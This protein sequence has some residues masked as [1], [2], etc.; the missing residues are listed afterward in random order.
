LG[1]SLFGGD[2]SISG[3]LFAEGDRFEM[4][5]TLLVTEGISGSLT[6]LTDGTS[7]LI[8]GT[9]TTIV[10]QS[11][12]SVVISSTPSTP[13]DSVQYN[14][15]GV[16]GGSSNFT[17]NGTQVFVGGTLRVG[18]SAVANG[19]NSIASGE[20]S[21]LNAYTVA[22]GKSTEARGE[23]SF[24]HGQGTIT[25]ATNSHAEGVQTNAS[26]AGSHAEGY[27]TVSSGSYSHA[28]GI[29]TIAS[30]S[31]QHVEGQYNI[32]GNVHSLL[33]IGNGT[34]EF[35]ATRSDIIRV[36]MN[37]LQLTG[38]LWQT[39]SG[40]STIGFM[41]NDSGSPEIFGTDVFFYV[42]GSKSSKDGPIPTVALFSGDVVVSGTLH[43]GS[44]LKVGTR[45]DVTGSVVTTQHYAGEVQLLTA[46]GTDVSNLTHMTLVSSTT[47][48]YTTNLP[49]G[50]HVGQ[51]KYILVGDITNAMVTPLI[52]ITADSV[53][54]VMGLEWTSIT[55]SPGDAATLTWT[56][57][58]WALLN[59]YGANVIYPS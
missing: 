33:V 37:S 25:H 26:E 45:L 6:Q 49:D 44:P 7:Y 8:Q 20:G 36:E 1:V 29:G 12:G 57:Q 42:S 55:F 31:G 35:D 22:H 54:P 50:L 19:S 58:G 3:S 28:E 4:S 18:N 51:I 14:N 23:N 56:S 10:S 30:G 41:G 59:V 53:R 46:S 47:G 43:G 39:N 24:A 2:V 27:R 9:N 17:Y 11:N 38:S 48:E 52:T 32:Q 21:A 16:F 5:G 40:S 34:D 13:S 15:A